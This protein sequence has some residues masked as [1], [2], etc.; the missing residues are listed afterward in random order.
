MGIKVFKNDN[1]KL[2]FATGDIRDMVSLSLN[3][4]SERIT[5]STNSDLVSVFAIKT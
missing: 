5:V 1:G 2:I 3:N 4:S